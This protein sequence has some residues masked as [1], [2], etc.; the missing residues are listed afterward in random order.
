[1]NAAMTQQAL[2]GTIGRPARI[3]LVEDSP[4]DVAMIRAALREGHIANDMHVAGDGEEA[5]EYLFRRGQFRDARRPDLIL[6]DLNL[7]KKDGCEV[8]AEVKA[9]GDLTVIPVV[10]L[11]TSAAESDVLRMYQ[12]HAN[13]YVTK[14]VGFEHFLSA[15][16]HIEDFWLSLVRL[17]DGLAP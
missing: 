15:I 11:T 4:S 9:D 13:S 17:C 8:L 10:V 3:L 2:H 14:P 12:L 1:M 5:L 6:L 7:P 16:Q